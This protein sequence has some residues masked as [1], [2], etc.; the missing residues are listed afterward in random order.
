MSKLTEKQKSVL[1]VAHKNISEYS[2]FETPDALG[3]MT[4]IFQDLTK[5]GLPIPEELQKIISK[6][7]EKGWL[8]NNV[9]KPRGAKNKATESFQLC[10]KLF[11]QALDKELI[12]KHGLTTKNKHVEYFAKKNHMT[13]QKIYAVIREYGDVFANVECDYFNVFKKRKPSRRKIEILEN[14]FIKKKD[15]IWQAQLDLMKKSP[16]S[17]KNRNKK[18]LCES[19]FEI[20]K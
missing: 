13:T 18:S 8:K 4:K 1:A 14:M 2:K 16:N 9:P 20:T 19:K 3:V 7:L 10:G 17:I 12:M 6:A 11:E 5:Y 15:R